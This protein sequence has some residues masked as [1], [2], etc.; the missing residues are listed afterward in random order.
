MKTFTFPFILAFFSTLYSGF[1]Q[2]ILPDSS[3]DFTYH[4]NQNQE[5]RSVSRNNSTKLLLANAT[6]SIDIIS[7][8]IVDADSLRYYYDAQ[9]SLDSSIYWRIDSTLALQKNFRHIFSY[10]SAPDSLKE[11]VGFIWQS[12]HWDNW[13]RIFYYFN[14]NGKKIATVNQSWDGV[15]WVQSDSLSYV[16]NV[17]DWLIQYGNDTRRFIYA[18]NY[19]GK[20]VE[21]TEQLFQNGQWE[22][23]NHTKISYNPVNGLASQ[24]LYEHWSSG[25]WEVRTRT[26]YSYDLN[27]RTSQIVYEKY[28]GTTWLNDRSLTYG[29]SPDSLVSEIVQQKWE[30]N[31]WTNNQKTEYLYDSDGDIVRSDYYFWYNG[32]WRIQYESRN[33]Y[34]LVSNST[35][36][37]SKH[38]FTILPNPA[39]SY[40]FLRSTSSRPETYRLINEKGQ[41]VRQFQTISDQ[42]VRIDC[43]HLPNGIY[44]VEGTCKTKN[45]IAK[46]LVV[47][48]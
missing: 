13:S 7:A 40:F 8:A 46:L 11:D 30:N 25:S 28:N 35:E 27:G 20:V 3:P 10:I 18:F 29:Y 21:S 36:P 4:P 2:T 37:E 6:S 14:S 23:L 34:Q 9:E 39:N 48:H 31:S 16:Y 41:L 17:Y 19:S 26:N 1:A 47:T 15:D 44:W 32:E 42:G 22:N 45:A 24:S 12:D 33:Y 5:N 43:S 38:D